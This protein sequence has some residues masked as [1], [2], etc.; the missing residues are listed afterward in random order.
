MI[1]PLSLMKLFC[2]TWADL[3]PHTAPAKGGYTVEGKAFHLLYTSW[4]STT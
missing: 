1:R 3:A 2:G 4:E